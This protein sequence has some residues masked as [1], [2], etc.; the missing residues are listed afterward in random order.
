MRRTDLKASLIFT[1]DCRHQINVAS[2]QAIH[3]LYI[4]YCYLLGIIDTW[5]QNPFFI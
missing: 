4:Q 1:T 5:Y 2:L 3:T